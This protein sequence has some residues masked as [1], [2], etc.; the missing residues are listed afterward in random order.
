MKNNYVQSF[1]T[2]KCPNVN[3]KFLCVTSKRAE[4]NGRSVED[5]TSGKR[6]ENGL[7]LQA[8]HEPNQTYPA[9][10]TSNTLNTIKL[11]RYSQP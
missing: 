5:Q 10:H 2:F 9:D 6:A 3:A 4:N 8:T 7:L 11:H 1:Q